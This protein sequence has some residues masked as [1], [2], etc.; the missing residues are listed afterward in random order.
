MLSK[1]DKATIVGIASFV[2]VGLLLYFF[3][4][5]EW[6]PLLAVSA[7]ISALVGLLTYKLLRGDLMNKY[8]DLLSK[9]VIGVE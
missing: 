8:V 5:L 4:K 7:I 6:Y 1:E 2:L 3:A 9:I